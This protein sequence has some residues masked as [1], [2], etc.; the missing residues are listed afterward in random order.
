MQVSSETRW[1][2]V[3]S[4]A[5]EQADSIP[6]DLE[7]SA[8]P[9]KWD[10]L[11][12]LSLSYIASALAQL[13]LFGVHD[14]ACGLAEL[15][16][17]G[18]VLKAHHRLLGRWCRRLASSGVLKTTGGGFVAAEP[19]VA[20]R[21]E[22]L[23]AEARELLRTDGFLVDYVTRCG[24]MLPGVLDGKVSVADTL[25]GEGSQE[26]ATDIYS[27]W[28]MSRYFNSIVRATVSAFV[29]CVPKSRAI[30]VLEIGAGT[31]GTT[32]AVMSACPADRV[33]Y[34]FS[35]VSEYFLSSAER[36][37]RG[38]SNVSYR[39]LDIERDP[40]DQGYAHGSFDV[41][42]AANVLHATKA[43]QETV[44]HARALLAPGGLLIVY[45]VTDP[46]TWLEI[47]FGLFEG[48]NRFDDGLRTADEPTLP[49]DAW[50]DLLTR[51]GFERV[52]AVPQPGS[53]AEV[54][55]AH[56]IVAQVPGA[57]DQHASS[58]PGGSITA[59]RAPAQEAAGPPAAVA[60][61]MT[62]ESDALLSA[63]EAAAPNLRHDMLVEFV[64][65]HTATVLR[66]DS[67]EV[68]D[69]RERLM[70]L[71]VDSLM[72][73][74]LRDRLAEMLPLSRTL[75]TTLIFDYPTIDAIATLLDSALPRAQASEI[76]APSMVSE[77]EATLRDMS[78]EEIESLLLK[79][80]D[81]L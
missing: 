70:D 63:L 5:R 46:P 39:V 50:V 75:P 55:R 16:R 2:R 69:R 57:L 40:A 18:G 71:G 28:G 60:G 74:E 58:G 52:I 1:E 25:F 27:R 22:A 35:D 12:R 19:L 64:R 33:A 51:T 26:L 45:E 23:I 81:T 76:D 3:A 11:E 20:G 65:A 66:R 34:V 78:E 42:I 6:I 54:L 21:P 79:K 36:R 72:A 44:A 43:L 10:V 8:Y 14:E 62:R 15:A 7:L 13:G 73:V 53:A 48:W 47:T 31:G 67:S 9:A 30:S 61:A 59:D 4:A 77:R 29:G 32:T 49:P 80:L 41:V 68:I 37:L 24:D 38:F 17:R 56:V